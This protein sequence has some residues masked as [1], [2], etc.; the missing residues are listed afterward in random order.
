MTNVVD[1]GRRALEA[2]GTVPIFPLPEAVLFP[3]AVLP[4][5]IF[6]PRYRKMTVDALASDRLIAIAFVE[7]GGGSV[8]GADA[9]A[10]LAGA[11]VIEGAVR[12]PDGRYVMR[13]RGAGRIEILEFVREEPYRIARVRLLEERNQEDGPDVETDK[14]RLLTVCAA[15]RHE[16]AGSPRQ[17]APID[18]RIPFAPAVNTLC[19]TLNM[20]AAIRLRLLEMDDVRERCRMLTRLLE[21]R[22]AE[23]AGARAAAGDSS[24]DEVH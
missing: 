17:A 3:H 14:H 1:E 11:G 22:W 19:Q 2:R 20:D 16:V 6:E 12:L 7:P 10:P 21:T 8:P 23:M 13:L 18:E 9:I 15:L 5:H 4:L 24:D